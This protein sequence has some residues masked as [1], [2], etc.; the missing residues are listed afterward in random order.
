MNRIKKREQAAKDFATK[1]VWGD[2]YRQRYDGFMAGALWADRNPIGVLDEDFC[3]AVYNY[4]NEWKEG[5]FGEMPL[6]KALREHPLI[7]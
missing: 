4:V 5:K 2:S 3:W 7:Y 1:G 6:Q